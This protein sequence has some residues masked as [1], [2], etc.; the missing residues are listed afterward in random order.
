MFESFTQKGIALILCVVL[1]FANLPLSAFAQEQ[2]VE[3]TLESYFSGTPSTQKVPTYRALADSM[4]EQLKNFE[5]RIDIYDFKILDTEE[6]QQIIIDI[7]S[8]GLPECFHIALG[9]SL[10]SR[11]DYLSAVVPTYIYSKSEYE[12]MLVECD[13][14]AEKMLSGIKNNSKLSDVE[15]LLLLHDRIAVACEYDYANYNLGS[16]PQ[17]S[18]TMYG[19]FVNEVAVCQ[20]YA[21][22]YA[23]LLDKLGIE[24]YYCASKALFHAWN[25]VI[26]NGKSYHVDITMDDLVWDVTGQVMHNNFLVSTEELRKNNH[27]AYDFD[28]SPTDTTYDNYFWENSETAFTLLNDEIYYIDSVGNHIM[29]YSD[30]KS[31]YDIKNHWM[32]NATQYYVGD[33]A[34]LSTDGKDLLFSLDDGIYKLNLTNGKAEIIHKPVLAEKFSVYGFAYKDGMLVYD[35]STSPVFDSETKKLFEY[36]VPYKA[37]EDLPY[38]PGDI[39][40]NE[41][42]DL[43]DVVALAQFIAGWEIECN[44]DALDVNGD[45]EETLTDV[46]H[47]ARYVADWDGIELH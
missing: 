44:T 32:A 30:Q 31:L 46:V 23:Y 24:N 13:T 36:K 42:V 22:A 17:I 4:N 6:N 8:G 20:G 45:G 28:S 43:I 10:A 12:K 35:L 16:I 18:H 33:Y 29:R 27:N 3:L 15:K 19:V 38:T 5:E 25:I 7:L 37:A 11:G 34:R 40:G 9:F 14:A 26:V 21:L 47:L 39:D 2:T 1:L 41:T